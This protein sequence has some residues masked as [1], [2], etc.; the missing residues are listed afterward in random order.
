MTKSKL[1]FPLLVSVLAACASGREAVDD[2]GREFEKTAFGEAPVL[3][4]TPVEAKALVE[5]A[6]AS[7]DADIPDHVIPHVFICVDTVGMETAAMQLSRRNEQ[8]YVQLMDAPRLV[9]QQ[10]TGMAGKHGWKRVENSTVAAAMR[11]AQ[12]DQIEDAL[13]LPENR[14]AL[15][16]ALGLGRRDPV[17]HVLF[18][19]VTIGPSRRD[20]DMAEYELDLRVLPLVDGDNWTATSTIDKR[21][22]SRGLLAHL[23]NARD[24]IGGAADVWRS[25]QAILAGPGRTGTVAGRGRR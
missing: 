3:A 7:L 20:P 6:F 12:L 23:Q 18:A 15:R 13:F 11:K 25:V 10:L 22:P 21:L 1:T 19:T 5:P 2:A 16:E 24:A 9:Q 4:L 17:D 14:R 8:L